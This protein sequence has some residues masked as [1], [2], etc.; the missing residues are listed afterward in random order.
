[1]K[2][3]NIPPIALTGTV[4]NLLNIPSLTAL[5]PVGFTMPAAHLIVTK[6]EFVNTTGAPVLVSFFKGLTGASLA[7]TEVYGSGLSIPANGVIPDYGDLRLDAADF[8]TGKGLGVTVRFEV[9]IDIA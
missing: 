7:G 2:K 3:L 4:A 1:M 6:A 9:E 8:L 5:T